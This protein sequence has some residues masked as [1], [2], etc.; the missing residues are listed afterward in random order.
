VGV[1]S[2]LL[3]EDWIATENYAGIADLTRTVLTW[4]RSARS[5]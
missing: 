2:Q 1:G 3:R 4:I 5:V